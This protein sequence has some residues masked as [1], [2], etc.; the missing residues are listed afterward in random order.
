[1][2]VVDDIS[3]YGKRRTLSLVVLLMFLLFLGRLYQLQ[4][5]YRDEY[6]RKSK[7]N[8]VRVVSTEPVRGYLY[9]RTGTRVVDN[10]PAF[11]VT[12]MPFEFDRESAPRLAALLSL[13]LE[14]LHERLEKG[15]MYS[16]FAPVKIKRDVDFRSLSALAEQRDRFPGVGYQSESKRFYPTRARATHILGYTKEISEQQLQ[17]LG[18]DYVQGDVVGSTGLEAL[19][20]KALRGKKGHRYS[21]VNAY[22]QVIGRFDDGNLDV[23]P[24]EGKDLILTMDFGLQ[25]VAESLM[26]DHRGALVALDPRDGGILALVSMPDY[27]LSLFSGV[28]P[29]GVWKKLDSDTAAPLFNRATMSRYPPG[30]TYKMVLALAAL[31]NHIVS[32]SWRVNCTGVFYV[33]R[34]PFSDLHIHGSVNMIEAIQ[35]SCNVYFYELM[36]KTGLDH[37]HATGKVFGFGQRTGIDLYEENTGLL[38]STAYMNGRYGEKGW[39]RGYLPSLAIGQGELGVTPLQVACYAMAIANRGL[40]HQPHAV[41]AIIDRAISREDRISYETRAL[42]I[43]P[44]L[45]DPLREGMRRVVE[46]PGGTGGLARI[47]GIPSAGKTGTAQNP[48]G[49]DH[50]WFMGFAPLEE[51]EIAIAVLVENAGFGGTQAAPIAGACMEHYLHAASARKQAE[52]STAPIASVSGSP[53]TRTAYRAAQP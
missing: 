51:P 48:H 47:A 4:L 36:M 43:R 53:T 30:S 34:K 46:E 5:I 7:E 1:M 40:Y 49:P 20:E 15:E 41:Q 18:K 2:N 14:V 52:Q 33:G 27:D 22:G 6:G 28:T 26:T 37:W 29:P 16:R 31:D 32:P 17:L 23:L 24:K 11:T 12:I 3:V 21:T 9:D 42:D 25:A 13:D 8:I 50:A 39:T 35:K 45:W 44:E 10:R 19:Y 38:P